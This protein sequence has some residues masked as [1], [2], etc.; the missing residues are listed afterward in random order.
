MPSPLRVGVVATA[1]LA[2]ACQG[3]PGPGSTT[4]PSPATQPTAGATSTAIPPL[5]SGPLEPG[6]YAWYWSGPA[7]TFEVPDGWTGI[8]GIDVVKH[9]DSPTEINWG[10]WLPGSIPVSHVYTDACKSE[11][12][13]E[14]IAGTVQ[15]LVDA[16]ETQAGTDATVTEVTLGGRPAQRIDLVQSPSVDRA[17]CRHGV[18]GPL[19]IWANAAETE[20]YAFAPGYSGFVHAL[21]LDGE[22][23]VF[24]AAIG[25]DA[26]PA[27]IEELEAIVS[28]V[29][30]APAVEGSPASP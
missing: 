20:F 27:E 19:Q 24:T 10:V 26:A 14:P 1:L 7:I 29:D 13:L 21:D 17:I 25:P 23:V 15:S 28:S 30:I 8:R 2:V 18:D 16:L 5:G 12:A 6:R 9:P 4:R 3:P 22:L 11:G